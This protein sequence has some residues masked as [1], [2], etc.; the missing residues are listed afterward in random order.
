MNGVFGIEI[1]Y[2]ILALGGVV[3]LMTL[4]GG[5]WAA[6]AGDII[7]M[8]IVLTI[9]LV[10]AFLTLR[11]P[12]IGGLSELIHKL[13]AKHFNWTYFDRPGV[14]LFFALTLLL[15][16]LVQNNSMSTTGGAKYIFVKNGRDA[17][18]SSLVSIFGF[19]FLPWVWMI[20]ALAATIVFPNLAK[21]F[22][23]VKN[24]NETAYVAMALKLLP[25]GLLGLLVCAVFAGTL[26]T[27]CSYLNAASGVFVRNFYIRVVNKGT[28]EARQIMIGRIVIFA[29]GVIWVLLA[30]YFNTTSP[31]LLDLL[32]IV[33]ASIG[34][35]MTIPLFY[36]IFFKKTPS[37]AAWSTMLAG[38]IP[39]ITMRIILRDAEHQRNFFNSIFSTATAFNKQEISDLNIGFT[40]AVLF[41]VCTAWYLGTTLFYRKDKQEYVKQVDDFFEE[42]DTPIDKE[43]KDAD[44]FD[45]DARQY[46]VLGNLCMIYGTFVL[47]LML[48]PNPM[49]ARYCIMF[50]GLTIAGAGL[51]IRTIGGYK[52]NLQHDRK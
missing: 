48:I 20:P 43:L 13:P 44:H 26:T 40:T 18:K 4:L 45:N 32:L 6:I 35:P 17:Q 33:S 46:I 39:S 34:I 15:N 36:G 7:Q 22:P 8:L 29:N 27:L 38:M 12:E 10:M 3:M 41:I 1:W 50:C 16:Q 28:S 25:K 23:N 14:I 11:L 31:K 2:L 21:E 42:M 19:I 37:W 47:S 24:P 5:S 9:T 52:R 49:L 51:I 30:A